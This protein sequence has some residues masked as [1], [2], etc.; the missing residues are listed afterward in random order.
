VPLRNRNYRLLWLANLIASFSGHVAMI[1]FPLVAIKH[2]GATDWEMGVLIGVEVLPFLLFS[3]PSGTW[4][5][6]FD[7]KRMLQACFAALAAV[8]VIVPAAHA[9]GLLNMGVLYV[10]GFLMGSIMCVE[11]T[12]SQVFT[13]ELVGRKDLVDANA[14]LMGAESGLKLI[15]PAAGGVMVQAFG[16]PTT[17]WVECV[18]ITGACLMLSPIRVTH[19]RERAKAQPMLPMIREGLAAV[20]ASPVLRSAAAL[21][22]CW[23]FLWHGVYALLV[24]HAS[25]DLGLSPA[26]LGISTAMGAAGILAGTAL[27]KRIE[28]SLGLGMGTLLGFSAAS[29]GWGL[30]AACVWVPREYTMLAFGVAYAV[31]DFGLC[32]GFVCY[33]S[34]RQAV[35]SDALLGRVVATMRW[36]SL[37]LAP[38]GSVAFGALSHA[39]TVRFS[40]SGTALAFGLAALVSMV[41]CLVAR[42][43]ALGK[44]TTAYVPELSSIAGDVIAESRIAEQRT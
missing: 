4:V 5:D 15:G 29:L 40:I 2:L 39:A 25:R 10:A 8:T 14:L 44:V 12:V 3:L 27:A 41:L 17:L 7:G 22:V 26:Q 18:L 35:T 6:R 36:L 16:A 33:T 21:M 11:G 13:T 38:L 9:F 30:M 43:T 37:L 20:W 32:I 34:L 24:L 31:M 23:Q 28:M 1:A 19:K 42:G